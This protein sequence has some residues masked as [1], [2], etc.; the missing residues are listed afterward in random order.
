[1]AEFQLKA[2]AS[3]DLLT[4]DELHNEL[5]RYWAARENARGRGVKLIRRSGNTGTISATAAYGIEGPQQGYVWAIRLLGLALSSAQ[6]IQAWAAGDNSATVP[7]G[8]LLGQM[9]SA[10]YGTVTWSNIQGPLFGG[11]YLT[12]SAGGSC[13]AAYLLVAVEVPAELLWKIAG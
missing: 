9:A 8:G 1:L 11:E 2:G 3:I 5:G 7:A 10:T 4:K 12:L 13:S 6:T